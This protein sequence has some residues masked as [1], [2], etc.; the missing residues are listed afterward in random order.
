MI[1]ALNI[2][3]ESTVYDAI[4]TLFM[5]DVDSLYVANEQ[6]ELAGLLPL[7]DLLR[8][9]MNKMINETPVTMVMTRTSQIN[10]CF[11][12]DL[13]LKAAGMLLICEWTHFP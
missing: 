2:R 1:P 8:A 11:D 13:L 12:D 4:T 10:T 6:G 7:K 9:S 5:Y 3:Q